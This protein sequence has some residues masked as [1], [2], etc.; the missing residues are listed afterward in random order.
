MATAFHPCSELRYEI[1]SKEEPLLKPQFDFQLRPS[2]E[3]PGRKSFF[4]PFSGNVGGCNEEKRLY[5]AD[6]RDQHR[7]RMNPTGRTTH[8]S[9]IVETITH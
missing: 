9:T 2:V 8:L 4:Q 1:S 7:F 5:F 6:D 3:T